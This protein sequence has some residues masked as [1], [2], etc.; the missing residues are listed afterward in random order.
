LRE[1]VD[2]LAQREELAPRLPQGLDQLGVTL[3]Q[4]ADPL[5]RLG[6]PL[7]E[8][9]G[10]PRRVRQFP[11]QQRY[12]LFKEPDLGSFRRFVPRSRLRSS[13]VL[14]SLLGPTT[15]TIV[16]HVGTSSRNSLTPTVPV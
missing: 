2:L 9:A 6:E 13:A 5:R 4:L 15:G 1:P 11:A 14:V 16:L 3:S 10:M 12:F 8:Q 7:L